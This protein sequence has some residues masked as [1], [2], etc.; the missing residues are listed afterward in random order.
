M[1]AC[2][3]ETWKSAQYRLVLTPPPKNDLR[4]SRCQYLLR[5]SL[6]EIPQRLSHRRTSAQTITNETHATVVRTRWQRYVTYLN[7]AATIP[8]RRAQCPS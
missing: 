5:C 4:T 8:S 6:D 2:L 3:T 7:D 1:C